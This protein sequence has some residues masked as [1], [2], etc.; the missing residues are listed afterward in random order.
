[1][2]EENLNTAGTTEA[3]PATTMQDAFAQTKSAEAK[4]TAPVATTDSQVV[5]QQQPVADNSSDP[6]FFDPTAVPEELLP[7]YKN[8][9]SAF[10]KKTQ[11]ISELT[12][13]AQMVDAFEANPEATIRQLANQYGITFNQAQ[14]AVEQAAPE[15]DPNW[16][17]AT[18]Q[19]VM[20]RAE[21]RAEQRIMEKLA[22]TINSTMNELKTLK[23]SETEK[24]LND[25]IPDWRSYE[26]EMVEI[27][28]KHPT[29]HDDPIKL[30]ELAMPAEVKEG[31]AY[32][33]ALDKLQK[34]VDSS[35]VTASNGVNVEASQPRANSFNEAHLQARRQLGLG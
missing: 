4:A 3:Q 11:N 25:T 22:P 27:L 35:K 13:K 12:R 8:M 26:T 2:A 6:T 30:A 14:Q 21:E 19:E 16:Q 9:Q 18:W 10:T 33:K 32:K 31:R 28:K 5:E 20:S 1:M 17:P 29:L 34:K 15:A 24:M 7:A 23:K